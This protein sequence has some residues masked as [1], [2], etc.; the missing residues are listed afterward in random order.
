MDWKERRASKA[1][2]GEGGRKAEGWARVVEVGGVGMW[3]EDVG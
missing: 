2:G 1:D 3:V